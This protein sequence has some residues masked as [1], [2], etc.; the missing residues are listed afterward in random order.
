MPV[1]SQPSMPAPAGGRLAGIDALRAVAMLLG[2]L[3]HSLIAYRVHPLPTWPYDDQVH[4]WAFDY[5]YLF[6]HS[7]RMSLFY[8]IA[9]YFCR[10]L[11]YRTG[12]KAFIS[13]RVK[14][15]LIP[16]AASLLVVLPFTIFPF[17]V[18]RYSLGN[19]GDWN[20]TLHLAWKQL[21]HWN[22]M[23]HLWFLYYLLMYYVAAIVLLR[24]Y[25]AGWLKPLFR[26][27]SR[28]CASPG[29]I[30][31]I[32]LPLIWIL[33]CASRELYLHV[34]TGILPGPVFL[35]FYFLFFGMGWMLHR[36]PSP[37]AWFV[38]TMPLTLPAGMLL[39][40]ILF[41][42]E[43]NGYY[44][45]SGPMFWVVK[46]LA[47]VQSITLVSGVIGFFLKFFASAGPRWRYISDASFWM[48]LL[49]LGLIA[50]LQVW[51]IYLGISPFLR[52]PLVLGITFFVTL[53][54][55]RYMVRYTIIGVYLHGKRER[56]I[57]AG[58]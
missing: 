41:Y 14:R 27:A 19:A 7:F 13:H 23:A 25:R 9:G 16:F 51:F 11:I 10:L 53:V 15:I 35:L 28:L 57:V 45:P 2:V 55:Y 5:L 33:L 4:H 34:D 8:L 3:F 46:A 40:G 58:K 22:G 32:S 44:Q 6:I 49:H 1:T 20:S 24:I 47:A 39:S 56:N 37:F 48:Y 30:V 21:L 52:F 29:R 42:I 31:A 18:Y 43:F 54:S 38:R 36:L 26:L 17:L 50:G 12:E